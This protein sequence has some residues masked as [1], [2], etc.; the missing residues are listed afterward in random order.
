MSGHLKSTS[1]S[2]SDILLVLQ[3]IPAHNRDI[4]IKVG[5]GLKSEYGD[6]GFSL[7]DSWSRN[8]DNYEPRAVADAWKSFR[9]GTITIGS[10]F[11]FA[12][13]HGWQS[14]LNNCSKSE[15]CRNESRIQIPRRDQPRQSNTTA[16]ALRLWMAANC[17][18]SFVAEH[19]YA[20]AKGIA[21][22]AGAA[23]GKASGKIIGKDADCIVV[24]VRDIETN[25]VQGVQ[26]IN[27]GGRKQTFGSLSGAALI[28]GN[29]LDKTLI[30]YVC[31]GWASAVSMVFH[32]QKGN[33][34]C[35]CAFGKSNLDKVAEN[36]AA[37]HNPSEVIILRERDE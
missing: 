25:K 3:Y 35:A 34:V 19:E 31:E 36:I 32:H 30:W 13:E 23:T 4:W 11:H 1:I 24:P 37:I 29:T 18:D 14:N 33:G 6:H 17:D 7:Y 2:Q 16:Y 26:C 8:A 21:H 27:S 20:K 28:L 9:G 5:M 15:K 10:I 22:A 12:K